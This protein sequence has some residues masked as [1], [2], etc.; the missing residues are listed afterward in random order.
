MKHDHDSLL[1]SYEKA[2]DIMKNR[3]ASFYQA[4]HLLPKKRFLGI[5][6]VYAFCR[7][8]DDISDGDLLKTEK[9]GALQKLEENL[10]NIYTEHADQRSDCMFPWWDAF[11]DT[12][13]NIKSPRKGFSTKLKD[14]KKTSTLSKFKL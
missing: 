1:Q 9:V 4:F 6:A 11:V 14:K 8:A 5:C 13:K 2:K 3:A 7:Y 10:R 12:V